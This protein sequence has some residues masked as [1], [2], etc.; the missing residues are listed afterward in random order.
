MLVGMITTT[1][2]KGFV[3]LHSTPFLY[4]KND[5]VYDNVLSLALQRWPQQEFSIRSKLV[6][7]S[8]AD[9]AGSRALPRYLKKCW[10]SFHT[11]EALY[12]KGRTGTV[13]LSS[14]E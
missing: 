7:H 11:R 3:W 1:N 4:Q 12:W 13:A 5:R 9:R 6:D 8:A 10:I 14:W 2:Q